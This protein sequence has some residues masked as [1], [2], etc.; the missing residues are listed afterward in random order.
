MEGVAMDGRCWM[1]RVRS[2]GRLLYAPVDALLEELGGGYNGFER[3]RKDAYGAVSMER[4]LS[5]QRDLRLWLRWRDGRMAFADLV[6]WSE[7]A[8]P[9]T[10]IPEDPFDLFEAAE[11][12]G[13]ELWE[14]LP[15]RQESVR[16]DG[17]R[18]VTKLWG[19]RWEESLFS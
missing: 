1:V 18:L 7:E 6:E 9:H 19:G 15:H 12:E 14:Y 10:E 11:G 13:S 3:W 4:L 17:V 2:E 16:R 8:I 5:V